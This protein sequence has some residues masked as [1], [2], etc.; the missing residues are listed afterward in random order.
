MLGM[1]RKKL[2]TLIE[3]NMYESSRQ[4]TMK[5]NREISK[6]YKENKNYDLLDNENVV[7]CMCRILENNATERLNAILDYIENLQ[8]ELNIEYN[9]KEWIEIEIKLA[10]LIDKASDYIRQTIEY[11]CKS[12][13][14]IIDSLYID[15][16]RQQAVYDPKYRI[17][18]IKLKAKVRRPSEELL[19]QQKS[20][21]ISVLAIII[22]AI[23]IY[24]DI[25]AH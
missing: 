19:V 12:Q 14:I 9:R 21:W 1:V 4:Y 3:N 23:A 24:N 11:E 17:D 8:T 22:A 2:L 18:E 10:G 7:A 13:N 25:M 6:L 5:T 15:I 16:F 20:F